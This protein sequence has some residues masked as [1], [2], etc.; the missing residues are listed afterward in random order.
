MQRRSARYA[1]LC[2]AAMLVG[3]AA[4][5]SLGPRPTGEEQLMIRW[6]MF[7]GGSFVAFFAGWLIGLVVD[8]VKGLPE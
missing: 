2:L 5:Q 1:V 8:R 7:L 6:L 3:S 4:Y